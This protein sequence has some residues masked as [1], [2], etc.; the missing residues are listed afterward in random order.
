MERTVAFE[1][2]SSDAVVRFAGLGFGAGLVPASTAAE[3]PGVAVLP[4]D[5][6]AARHAV[7]L[8]HRA[9]APSTPQRPGVPGPAPRGSRDGVSGQP[10][11]RA[12]RP[13]GGA[14]TAS[15]C[16]AQASAATPSTRAGPACTT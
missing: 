9:P 8:V 5:D 6:P 14:G 2:R 11:G 16:S 1:L 12:T 13:G 7:G 4:V 3:A 15:G 10:A